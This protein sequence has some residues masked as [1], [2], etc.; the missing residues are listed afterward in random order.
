ML[1]MPA[2]TEDKASTAPPPPAP[3]LAR[4]ALPQP[5][6]PA[7]YCIDVINGNRSSKECL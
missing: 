5:A 7:R 3:R 1:G 4:A 2:A 6:E